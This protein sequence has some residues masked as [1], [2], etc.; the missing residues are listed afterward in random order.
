M[1][2][3]TKDKKQSLLAKI[4]GMYE[5]KMNSNTI[6]YCIVMENL[7]INIKRDQHVQVYDLKGSEM[8]RLEKD[9]TP[10]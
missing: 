8:N 3:I 9:L 2:K 5:I 10:G 6:V 4:Y 1:N 7:F